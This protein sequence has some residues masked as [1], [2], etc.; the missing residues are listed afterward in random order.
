MKILSKCNVEKEIIYRLDGQ[1]C[2][3]I[4]VVD[5]LFSMEWSTTPRNSCPYQCTVVGLKLGMVLLT[6]QSQAD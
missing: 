2:P 4:G 3:K 6:I 5:P 1:V